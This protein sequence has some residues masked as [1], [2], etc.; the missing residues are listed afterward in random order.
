MFS[1]KRAACRIN[2]RI[3]K[4]TKW[5]K[6]P[7]LVQEVDWGACGS[8]WSLPELFLPE[9]A[10]VFLGH[11]LLVEENI[12]ALWEAVLIYRE[13]DTWPLWSSSSK[14]VIPVWSWENH[15][16]NPNLIYQ[17][18]DQ[19][20]SDWETV[21]AQRRLRR[22]EGQMQCGISNRTPA[23]EKDQRQKLRKFK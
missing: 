9:G 12:W 6:T 10:Q 2:I 16:T 8:D 21:T 23:Q 11:S 5:N 20:C 1:R 15:Q 4:Q 3:H 19:C 7:A 14:L 18:P 17:M 22:R 13:D